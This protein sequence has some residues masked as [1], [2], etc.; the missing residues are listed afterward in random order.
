MVT[1]IYGIPRLDQADTDVLGLIADQKQRLRLF[2]QNN[3]NRWM[4]SLRRSTFARAMVGSNSIEGYHATVGD[5][6]AV[7]QNE[8]TMEASDETRAALEGYRDAMTYIIQAAND[9]HFEFAKQF[10]KSLQFMMLRHDLSKKPGQWRTGAIYVVEQN[11]AKNV[12]EAPDAEQ[13]N[14]LV[15]ELVTALKADNGTPVIVRAAMAHLNLTMIHPFKDGNGRMARALQTL[16]LA[17]E[18]ILH[19]VFSSIEE[20]LGN[21]T[22]EYYKVLAETGEGKWSPTNDALSWVRFCLTAHYQQAGTLI[23][24]NDEYSRLFDRIV[25]LVKTAKLPDRCTLPVFDAALGWPIT[26]P[27]YRADAEVGE[28][29]ATRDLKA[30]CEAG[31]FEPIGEKR[32]RYYRRT[33]VL[34]TLRNNVRIRRPPE[35]PYEVIKS[36]VQYHLPFIERRA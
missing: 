11:T 18:G 25:E 21:H 6:I 23:R 13:V 28:Y 7:V 34:E 27:R 24:R 33:K 5:A 3:P 35:N 20:W 1:M 26:S 32:G 19:P 8:Q 14:G 16:V 30:L 22:P 31:L 36:E 2:T 29:M 4:G 10:L 9:P 17:R 12:D 15:E